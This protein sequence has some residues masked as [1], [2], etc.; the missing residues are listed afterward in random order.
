M[1]P[2]KRRQASKFEGWHTFVTVAALLVAVQ[3]M[4]LAGALFSHAPGLALSLMALAGAGVA[5]LLLQLRE[6]FRLLRQP[7]RVSVRARRPSER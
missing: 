4:N 7:V 1:N 2:P 6:Q 3:V 5:Y